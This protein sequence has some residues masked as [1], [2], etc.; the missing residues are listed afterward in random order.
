MG[1]EK[2]TKGEWLTSEDYPIHDADDYSVDCDYDCGWTYVGTEN[3]TVAM[4]VTKSYSNK[5]MTANANLIA[6]APDMYK[7]LVQMVQLLDYYKNYYGY[8]HSEEEQ[9]FIKKA[10]EVVKRVQGG[11]E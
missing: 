6:A 7:S 4:V 11:G 10:K 8:S 2:F 3:K 1:K 9:A 5:E